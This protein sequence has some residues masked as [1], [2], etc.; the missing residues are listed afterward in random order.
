MREVIKGSIEECATWPERLEPLS[1][2]EAVHR[3]LNG[4]AASFELLMRRYN[5]RV[6]RVVRS[7]VTDDAEAED[8]VQE[9]YV[10]AF[11]NLQQFAGRATFSTWLTKIAVYEAMAR[12]R[13]RKFVQFVDLSDPKNANLE[14]LMENQQA[15]QSASVNE[16]RAVLAKAIDGLPDELRTVFTMRVVEEVDTAETAACLDLSEANVKVRLHRARSLLRHRIDEQIGAGVRKVYQ[17]DGDRCN[18]IVE[19]VLARLFPKT[20]PKA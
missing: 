14:P 3:V 2:G 11:E 6:F 18:R 8:V 16:L 5:Q 13:R 20:A 7:I 4:D 1:D 19:A 10:R 17:F 15:E 12:Q 9:A